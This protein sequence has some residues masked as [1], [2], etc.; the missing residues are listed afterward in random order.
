MVSSE[1]EPITGAAHRRNARTYAV[2][3]AVA[4]IVAVCA[5]VI[6]STHTADT[7]LVSK[8]NVRD[9]PDMHAELWLSEKVSRGIDDC[10]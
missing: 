9:H 1:A 8:P 2:L 4:G 7:N 10:R 3:G 6:T 5:V